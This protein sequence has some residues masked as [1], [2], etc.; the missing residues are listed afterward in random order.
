MND[1]DKRLSFRHVIYGIYLVHNTTTLSN[2]YNYFMKINSQRRMIMNIYSWYARPSESTIKQL[3]HFSEGVQC[4]MKKKMG[5]VRK[6]ILTTLVQVILK[7][8]L[9]DLHKLGLLGSWNHKMAHLSV[10]FSCKNLWFTQQKLKALENLKHYVFVNWIR[11]QLADFFHNS[12]EANFGNWWISLSTKL[13]YLELRNPRIMHKK[14]LH[15][16]GVRYVLWWGGVIGLHFIDKAVG[17]L[18]NVNSIFYL[19]LDDNWLEL[20]KINFED[21]WIQIT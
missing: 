10:R 12:D 3:K 20:C 1:G 11:D 9:V 8:L 2:Y 19:L 7:Y 6:K 13:S 15:P 17:E 21:T 4:K 16:Q 18:C 5:V 14:L